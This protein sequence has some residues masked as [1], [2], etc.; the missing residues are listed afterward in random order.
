M[1]EEEPKKLFSYRNPLYNKP[2]VLPPKVCDPIPPIPHKES[3]TGEEK[4][5]GV[6]PAGQE[7]PLQFILGTLLWITL[8]G[9]HP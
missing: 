6:T 2:S 4:P 8:K 9:I 3:K 7:R 5:L 1:D